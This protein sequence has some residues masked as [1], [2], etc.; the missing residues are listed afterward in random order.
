MDKNTVKLYEHGDD[1]HVASY[2]F[3]GDSSNELYF[4]AAFE[5]PATIIAVEDAF[6]KGRM[7]IVTEDGKFKPVSFA[8]G[9]VVT[10]SAGETVSAVTWSVPED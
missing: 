5:K 8:D 3:Y 4:D 2:L 1:L 7:T 6:T 10:I 9:E